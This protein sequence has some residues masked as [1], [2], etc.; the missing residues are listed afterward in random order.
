MKRWKKEGEKRGDAKRSMIAALLFFFLFPYICSSFGS[1]QPQKIEKGESIGTMWIAQD[2]LWGAKKIPMEEYLLGM[3]AATIPADYEMETLKA[4]AVLLRSWCMSLMEKK[5]GIKQACDA[6]LKQNY[7]TL[8]QCQKMWGENYDANRN[9]MN[10]ALQETAGMILVWKGRIIAPPFFRISN[11]MT[12]DV[13]EYLAHYQ[14]WG[15]LKQSECG[16][17]VEAPEYVSYVQ[18]NQ[19]DFKRKMASLLNL[20]KW[21]MDRLV[22][23]RDSAGYVKKVLVGEKEIEGETFRYEMGL[24]SACFTLEKQDGGIEFQ[25]KGMGHGFG[26]SQY[27]ANRL[28]I[29]GN[30]FLSLFQYF[31]SDV[32]LEKI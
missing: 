8:E 22:L 1:I 23:C 30:D 18:V 14:E 11:G 24:P 7:L 25:I 32:S 29:E 6:Q 15:Y 4:Q 3:M 28:V 2:R 17:D 31:F 9:K 27:K 5:D 19:R 12:R 16:E 20:S 26:F 21:D 10:Q 13:T